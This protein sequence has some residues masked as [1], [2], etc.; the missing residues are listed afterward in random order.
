VTDTSASI[1]IR[2]ARDEDA[3]ALIGL[4]GPIWLSYPGIVFDVDAE[5]PELRA[6]ASAFGTKGGR[7]W[8]AEREGSVVGSAG[9]APA[10]D[11]SGAELHKLYVSPEIRRAGLA[12][13]LLDRVETEARHSG[14]QFLELWTDSRFVEAHAF[15]ERHGFARLPEV[16]RLDDLSR[17][18]EYRY[19][20]PL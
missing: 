12:S 7:F 3:D 6:I 1:A 20:R 16:R 9:M 8:V 5:V 15:Y 10:A 2:D 11:P 18:T 14:A 17:S 4:I 13:R 19:R